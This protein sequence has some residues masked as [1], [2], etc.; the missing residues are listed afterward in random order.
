VPR[1]LTAAVYYHNASA[2]RGNPT[3]Q[4]SLAFF[5]DTG[6]EVPVNRALV[7]PTRPADDLASSRGK[8]PAKG[9]ARL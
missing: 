7:R 5:Y 9:L 4:K 1:N 6:K 2:S 8:Q 3:A